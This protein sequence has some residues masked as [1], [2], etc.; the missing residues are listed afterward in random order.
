MVRIFGGFYATSGRG[1]TAIVRGTNVQ[2]D[3]YCFMSIYLDGRALYSSGDPRQRRVDLSRD[4]RIHEL[5]AI[6]VYRSAAEIPGA[7][8]GTSSAYGVILLWTRRAP[9]APPPASPRSGP[10]AAHR[11]ADGA[12][13]D[14]RALSDAQNHPYA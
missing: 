8:G 4:I 3:E 13:G 5:E 10:A 2:R 9:S 11:D 6:E 12:A 14:V 1:E 7:Y